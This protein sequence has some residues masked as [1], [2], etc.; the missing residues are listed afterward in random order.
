MFGSGTDI[1]LSAQGK[2]MFD[3]DR[4]RCCAATYGHQRERFTIENSSRL[5]PM[6]GL[7]GDRDRW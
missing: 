1:A 4:D 7:I 5:K 6:P 3:Q 2:E